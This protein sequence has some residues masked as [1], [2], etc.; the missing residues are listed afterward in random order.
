MPSFPP[1]WWRNNGRL[2][3]VN[4]GRELEVT[5]GSPQLP[6]N[7]DDPPSPSRLRGDSE[8]TMK[9]WLSPSSHSSNEGRTGGDGGP[10]STERNDYIQEW[11]VIERRLWCIVHPPSPHGVIMAHATFRS[12][13]YIRGDYGILKS[14]KDHPTFSILRWTGR[15]YEGVT[16]PI[17]RK[18]V[19]PD[20]PWNPRGKP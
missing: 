13:G 3:S 2:P 1:P 20:S 6:R 19:V 8:M 11:Q 4:P 5:M 10:P 12:E 18:N 9:D 7:N 14:L 17:L 15:D 16:T